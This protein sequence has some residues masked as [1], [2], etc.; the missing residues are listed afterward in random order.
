MRLLRPYWVQ[1]WHDGQGEQPLPLPGSGGEEEEE[2]V[3]KVVC[4]TASRPRE[5]GQ[6]RQRH[7]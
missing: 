1:G 3:V 2:E 4:V 5:P 6:H 7:R